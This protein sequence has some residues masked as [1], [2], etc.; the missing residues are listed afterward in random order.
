[1]T[2][3]VAGAGILGDLAEVVLQDLRQT[4]LHCN[5]TFGFYRERFDSAGIRADDL[6]TRGPA[7]DAW[8]SPAA[9]GRRPRTAG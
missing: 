2:T 8:S 1:M 9:G 3:A 5:A 7:G 4:L 6:L